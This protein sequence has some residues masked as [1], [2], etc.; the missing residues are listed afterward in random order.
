MSAQPDPLLEEWLGVLSELW[1]SV[2]KPVDEDRLM[3]YREALEDLPLGV[4]KLAVSRVVRENVRQG[5]PPPGVV[6]AAV[7]KELGDPWDVRQALENWAYS[8]WPEPKD[9][10]C[11]D[12]GDEP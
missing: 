10:Y 9:K 3:V 11:T 6:W 1:I 7:R 5:V 12:P 4:L 2:G 8:Y